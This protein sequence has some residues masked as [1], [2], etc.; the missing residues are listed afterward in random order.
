MDSHYARQPRYNPCD[1]FFVE[2][3]ELSLGERIREQERDRAKIRQREIA[4]ELSQVTSDEYLEEIL[5]HMESME[6]S[7]ICHDCLLKLIRI[8]NYDARCCFYRYPA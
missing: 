2:T 7:I 4:T 6:V 5:D 8:G 1:S 3:D